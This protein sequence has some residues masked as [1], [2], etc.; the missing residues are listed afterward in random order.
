RFGFSH[1]TH[2]SVPL[3]TVLKF[4]VL[5]EPTGSRTRGPDVPFAFGPS[6]KNFPDSPDS[7]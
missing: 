6:G 5:A 7:A 4:P 2:P 1:P 3:G